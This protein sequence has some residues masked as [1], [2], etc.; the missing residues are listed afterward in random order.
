MRQFRKRTQRIVAVAVLALLSSG[1]LILGIA[2]GHSF[3]DF[4]R[5]PL[6][7]YTCASTMDTVVVLSPSR[8]D[9][10]TARQ[11]AREECKSPNVSYGWPLKKP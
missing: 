11:L 2:V 8:S 10:Q 4:G 9:N 6:V 7:N 1:C 3:R 5:I